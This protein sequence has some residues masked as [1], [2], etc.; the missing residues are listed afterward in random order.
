MYLHH[1]KH[2]IRAI[3]FFLQ[4]CNGCFVRWFVLTNLFLCPF[5]QVDGSHKGSVHPHISMRCGAVQAQEDTCV[6]EKRREARVC[7]G[8]DRNGLVDQEE[9]SL[10]IVEGIQKKHRE[11][12]KGERHHPKARCKIPCPAV[13]PTKRNIDSLAG[14]TEGDTGPGGSWSRTI[15]TQLVGRNGLEFAKL[16]ILLGGG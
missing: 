11:A 2:L 12:S 3:Q 16:K 6:C 9:C 14:R 15:K 1:E 5:I 8:Q 13:P 4:G 10:F 7:V